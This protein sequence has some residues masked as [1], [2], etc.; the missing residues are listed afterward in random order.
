M[1]N[2]PTAPAGRLTYALVDAAGVIQSQNYATPESIRDVFVPDGQFLHETTGILN[3]DRWFIDAP[4]LES[5]QWQARERADNPF[6]EQIELDD[7]LQVT[8]P[9]AAGAT[10][11]T[12][13]GQVHAESGG[14]LTVTFPESGDQVL[15][16]EQPGR[17]Y[18]AIK[19]GVISLPEVRAAL[20][21]EI[22]AAR[23]IRLMGPVTVDGVTLDGD[24]T[25]QRNI[26]EAA[27]QGAFAVMR[28]ETDWSKVWITADNLS[29]TLSATDLEA[30]ATVIG[31]RRSL[32]Y[33]AARTA[34]DAVLAASAASAA[35]AARDAYLPGS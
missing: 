1:P 16:I 4:G 22:D 29:V 26:T 28:G 5:A 31:E 24:A 2:M 33:A 19:V 15:R 14:M 21:A 18:R 30:F 25:A 32:E 34:K 7:N 9:A 20:C 10:V 27:I 11:R 17:S 13:D 8:V 23:D 12:K 35:T 6:G 3:P